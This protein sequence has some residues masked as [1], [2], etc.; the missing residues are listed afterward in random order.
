MGNPEEKSVDRPSP[1]GCVSLSGRHEAMQLTALNRIAV[2]TWVNR[3][4]GRAQVGR[5]GIVIWNQEA[6]G[7]KAF[8]TDWV[9]CV[10]G[11][12][13][14]VPDAVFPLVYKPTDKMPNR[15]KKIA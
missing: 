8:V 4:G 14:V 10:Y 9:V 13:L 12:F 3:R 7:A 11:K 15:R 2:I 6:R 5:D 1:V